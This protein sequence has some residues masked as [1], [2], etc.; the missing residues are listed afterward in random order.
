MFILYGALFGKLYLNNSI[1]VFTH[2]NYDKKSIT[3]RKRK[4]NTEDIVKKILIKR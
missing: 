4:G 2:W 1:L 3:D